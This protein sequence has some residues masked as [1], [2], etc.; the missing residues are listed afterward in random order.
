MLSGTLCQNS[1]MHF[2]PVK[3]NACTKLCD[4]IALGAGLAAAI[5]F[6]GL[7]AF[8]HADKGNNN[9]FILSIER[10]DKSFKA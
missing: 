9:Y 1:G 8:L 3:S 7:R 6:K 2:A 5:L 10:R 4:F